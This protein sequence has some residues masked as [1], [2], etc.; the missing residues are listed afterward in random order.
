MNALGLSGDPIDV[1]NMSDS[2]LIAIDNTRV[3]VANM[4]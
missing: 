2:M 1:A 4:P 3:L